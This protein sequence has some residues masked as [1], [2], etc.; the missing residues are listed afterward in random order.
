MKKLFVVNIAIVLALLMNSCASSNDVVS[1][2]LISKRKY[3]KGLFVKKNL[4]LKSD[5]V[6]DAQNYAMTENTSSDQET[7]PQLN[8][9]KAEP[10]TDDVLANNVAPI[11]NSENWNGIQIE[12]N[13]LAIKPKTKEA[14]QQGAVKHSVK[15]D[16]K[17]A[18]KQELK[19]KKAVD[20]GDPLML[21]ILILL[22][23]FLPP[24]AIAIYRG[25]D[26]IFWLDLILFVVGIGGFW[27]LPI[28][29]LAALAAVIIAFLVIFDVI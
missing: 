1:N 16:F 17:K 9:K 5:G 22:A 18:F 21:V 6:E 8:I 25:I 15:S 11:D 10:M 3:T 4:R 20:T 27:F 19:A 12:E 28:A 2:R 29:G 26:N 23:L 13:P 7:L 24:V 14:S